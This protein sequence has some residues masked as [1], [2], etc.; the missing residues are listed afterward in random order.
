MPLLNLDPNL[1]QSAVLPHLSA[2]DLGHLTC[3]C[4]HMLAVVSELDAATWHQAA[5]AVLLPQH[6]ALHAATFGLT[7]SAALLRSALQRYSYA[8]EGLLDGSYHIGAPSLD[9]V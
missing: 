7:D 2:A 1:L 8:R 5:A 6:P 9:I 3:T 4:R